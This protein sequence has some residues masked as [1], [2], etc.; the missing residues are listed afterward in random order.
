MEPRQTFVTEHELLARINQKLSRS[1]RTMRV[2]N[3]GDPGRS[4]FGEYH[5]IDINTNQAEEQQ[6]DLVRWGYE[7]GVLADGEVP[8]AGD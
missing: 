5:L 2:C 8:V 3:P 4:R 1:G 7:L 6:C